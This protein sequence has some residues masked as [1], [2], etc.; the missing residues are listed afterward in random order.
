MNLIGWLTPFIAFWTT[1][2]KTFSIKQKDAALLLAL[3]A[4]SH[5]SL[6]MKLLP[7]LA[8]NFTFNTPAPLSTG[9]GLPLS[10]LDSAPS[11]PK[12]CIFWT[13]WAFNGLGEP[14]W[15]S[16][17]IIN[18]D[19]PCLFP[20]LCWNPKKKEWSLWHTRPFAFSAF[21]AGHL[22]QSPARTS[23][24]HAPEVPCSAALHHPG[25]PSLRFPLS[26]FFQSVTWLPLLLCTY[27]FNPLIIL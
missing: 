27:A 25:H 8:D 9:V 1:A 5:K 18:W 19:S 4:V 24:G 7:G 16:A 6:L 20:S 12:S 14:P 22:C 15:C 17:A 2:E 13:I 10:Q 21:L 3:W 11:L 23:I 26:P